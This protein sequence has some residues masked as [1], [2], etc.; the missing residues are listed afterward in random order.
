MSSRT[1][2]QKAGYPCQIE[3]DTFLRKLFVLNQS[4]LKKGLFFRK[5]RCSRSLLRSHFRIQL[6]QVSL[7][8][9]KKQPLASK[10]DTEGL[11]GCSQRL[12]A[13]AAYTH[14]AASPLFGAFLCPS[15]CCGGHYV[16]FRGSSWRPRPTS[17]T[18]KGLRLLF[19][20]ALVCLP[21]MLLHLW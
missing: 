8:F 10:A 17:T 4:L 3:T 6:L 7:L 16:D 15:Q 19:F 5:D 1:I 20:T 13:Y 21:Y 2:A 18:K 14:I 12:K 11:K 9:W